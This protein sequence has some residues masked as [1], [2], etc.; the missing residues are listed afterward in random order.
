MKRSRLWSVVLLMTTSAF[1]VKALPA[2][3]PLPLD[4]LTAEERAIADSVASRDARVRELL[5]GTRFIRVNTDFIAVK[6]ANRETEDL[7]I[8]RTAEVLFYDYSSDIGLRVLVDI[9]A[10][11]VLDLVKVPGRSVPINR[12]EVEQAARLALADSRVVGLFGREA[13]R[14]HVASG[15]ATGEEIQSPR[16]EGLKV[17]GADDN[18]P[19]FRHRCVV[20]FFRVNNR[21]VNMNRVTVDLTAQRVL[22]KEG[23]R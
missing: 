13:P 22:L 23:E 12:S 19:C 2:Q 21:Y 11:R 10:R 5:P 16:I 20:L 18:D 7:P 15:A 14:F 9:A 4:P 6:E 3:R 17:V 1:I 8:R